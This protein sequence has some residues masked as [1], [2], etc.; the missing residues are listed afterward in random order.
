MARNGNRG[1]IQAYQSFG[2]IPVD[3]RI[4]A[5]FKTLVPLITG[6]PVPHQEPGI[7]PG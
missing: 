1:S 6:Y 3:R 7:V 4:E 2:E 5:F